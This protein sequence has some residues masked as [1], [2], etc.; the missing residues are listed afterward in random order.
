MDGTG[1]ARYVVDAVLLESRSPREVAQAHGISKSWIYE[2]IKRYRHERRHEPTTG[3][4]RRGNSRETLT[5]VQEAAGSD[6]LIPSG[7]RQGRDAGST[8]FARGPEGRPRRGR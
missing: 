1:M 8:R 4:G 2:M 3:R 7:I 6:T 5:W